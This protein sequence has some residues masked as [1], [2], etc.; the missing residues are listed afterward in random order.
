M[1]RLWLLM[2][3]ATALSP[4]ALAQRQVETEQLR[5]AFDASGN[6]QSAFACFPACVGDKVR[7]QQFGDTGVVVLPGAGDA[8][9]QLTEQVGE[10]EL[11]LRFESGNGAVRTWRIPRRGYRLELGLSGD[12]PLTL[13]SGESFRPRDAAGFG[14][15]LEKSRYAVIHSGDVEQVGFDDTDAEPAPV[16]S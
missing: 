10:A 5:L 14:N 2:L 11:A 7:L 4:D 9:W 15:W 12:G 3:L 6:L 16:D 13:R 1:R 8:A